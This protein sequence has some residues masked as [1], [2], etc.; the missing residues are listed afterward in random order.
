MN[1]MQST[2]CSLAGLLLSIGGLYLLATQKFVESAS[3]AADI[4]IPFFGRLKTNYPSLVAIFIGAVLLVFPRG[5]KPLTMVPV[6]GKVASAD[7]QL[8]MVAII[9]SA[10]EGVTN[11][12]G[13]FGDI[14]V[15]QGETSY[16]GIAFNGVEP[17][18][19]GNVT[20]EKGHGNFTASLDSSG[21]P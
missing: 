14:E 21:K 11:S 8:S 1:T 7:K 13:S 5:V 18:Y 17:P 15:P 20:F 19:I 10:F 3:G 9:P 6:S 12:D 4:E 16:T 2:A